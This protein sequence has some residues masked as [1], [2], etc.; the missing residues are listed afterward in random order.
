MDIFECCNI[1]KYKAIFGKECET[2][3]KIFPYSS[4]ILLT[5]KI[6]H[7]AIQTEAYFYNFSYEQKLSIARYII[8][9]VNCSKHEKQIDYSPSQLK[10]Q[11]KINIA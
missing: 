6:I 8:L 3:K 11:L 2:L 9:H 4:K 5:K 1:T 10:D 7:F